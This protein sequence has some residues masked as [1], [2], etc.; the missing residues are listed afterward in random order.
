MANGVFNPN[1]VEKSNDVLLGEGVVYWDHDEATETCFG[2]TKGGSSFELK[3]E[4][5]DVEY[6]GQYGV[7]KGL[8]SFLRY[9]PTLTINLLKMTYTSFFKGIPSTTTQGA[10]VDGS[11]NKTVFNLDWDS[12]DVMKNVTFKG[13]KND[14]KV[15]LIKVLNAINIDEIELEFKPDDEVTGELVYTGCYAYATPTTPPVEIWDYV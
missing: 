1:V 11:Y 10:D 13:S 7:T 12:T 3:R 9:I 8:K 5:K 14:G 6:D 2:A 4:I 15:C